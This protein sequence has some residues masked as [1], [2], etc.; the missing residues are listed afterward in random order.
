MDEFIGIRTLEAWQA[1]VADS[2]DLSEYDKAYLLACDI[3]K[4]PAPVLR[5]REENRAFDAEQE[6]IQAAAKQGRRI[7]QTLFRRYPPLMSNGVMSADM[8]RILP[9]D[10]LLVA[11]PAATR[12]PIRF[13]RIGLLMSAFNDRKL[14]AM[15]ALFIYKS[16]KVV[17]SGAPLMEQ[18]FYV[19]QRFALELARLGLRPWLH[20]A[21]VVNMVARSVTDAYVNLPKLAA[22][23][24][25]VNYDPG[26]FAGA[27]FD[28]KSGHKDASGD[29]LVRV[30]VLIFLGGTKVMSGS[31]THE[32]IAVADAAAHEICKPFYVPTVTECD[33]RVYDTSGQGPNK[34]LLAAPAKSAMRAS[35]KA[36]AEALEKEMKSA[37]ITRTSKLRFAMGALEWA[38]EAEPKSDKVSSLPAPEAMP[39]GFSAEF[40]QRRPRPPTKQ[41]KPATE[42]PRRPNSR[43]KAS[44]KIKELEADF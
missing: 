33:T 2:A 16:G 34:A 21:A 12:A 40:A 36:T 18:G 20:M 11:I 44:R 8:G 43:P 3:T 22:S 38:N 19:L 29:V 14:C 35:K 41:R 31:P 25:S 37:A 1:N 13:P 26:R 15:P 42:G 17:V 5:L 4:M 39:V 24:P 23:V 10:Q 28:W 32:H 30:P 7:P 27:Q 6:M 9:L